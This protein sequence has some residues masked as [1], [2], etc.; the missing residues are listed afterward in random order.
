[1]EGRL[2]T[3]QIRSISGHSSEDSFKRYLC[4]NLE[5]EAKEIIKRYMRGK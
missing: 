2:S 4:H 3:E 5:D 1:M